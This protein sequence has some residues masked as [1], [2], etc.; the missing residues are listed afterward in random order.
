[1]YLLPPV[2]VVHPGVAEV[3]NTFDGEGF[4]ACNA[5]SHVYRPST[6][7][8]MV[9]IVKNASSQGIPVRASGVST[10]S[11]IHFYARLN[12]LLFLVSR[13]RICGVCC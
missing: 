7:D 11:N 3:Y 5:V 12:I 10:P 6:V 4:P 13:M 1:M 2:T 8:E 9:E